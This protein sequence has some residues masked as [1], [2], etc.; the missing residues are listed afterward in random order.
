MDG[1]MSSKCG[2]NKRHIVKQLFIT[3]LG[4]KRR[5]SIETDARALGFG[6]VLSQEKDGILRPI[7]FASK[8]T[9]RY[10][11]LYGPTELEAGAIHFAV[12]K[13]RPYILGIKCKIYTD[14]HG[15]QYLL[16]SNSS[17][18]RIQRWA[19][20]LQAYDLEIINRPGRSNS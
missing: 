16:T 8:T 1:R 5:I 14:H 20:K 10:E 12:K 11:K 7:S 2:C 6:A 13:F 4:F 3:F 17:N 19:L 9:D 18:I 15:L